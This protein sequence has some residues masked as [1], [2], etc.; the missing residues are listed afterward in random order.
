MMSKN[1]R[2]RAQKSKSHIRRQQQLSSLMSKATSAGAQN[3]ATA[4]AT[5]T[6]SHKEPVVTYKRYHDLRR[7]IRWAAILVALNIGFWLSIKF[8][9]IEDYLYNLIKV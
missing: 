4:K 8:S 2:T 9:N 6:T 7:S 5:K 3:E 1:R